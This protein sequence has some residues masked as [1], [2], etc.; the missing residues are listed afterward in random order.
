[1]PF[2]I[3]AS[4]KRRNSLALRNAATT[5]AKGFPLLPS[6]KSEP[7][8]ATKISAALAGKPINSINAR[9][10]WGNRFIVNN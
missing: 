8:V 3:V 9:K 1:M 4:F 5:L 2:A 6:F 7:F 10:H